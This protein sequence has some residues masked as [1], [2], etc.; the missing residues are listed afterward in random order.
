M[1]LPL[2]D[3]ERGVRACFWIGPTDCKGIEGTGLVAIGT[4]GGD[5]AEESAGD[6]AVELSS[7]PGGVLKGDTFR[8]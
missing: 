6:S 2:G 8:S 1:F 7:L 5:E 4:D 3:D